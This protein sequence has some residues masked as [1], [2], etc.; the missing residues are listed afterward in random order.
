MFGKLT[1]NVEIAGPFKIEV[2]PYTM[3]IS[4]KTDISADKSTKSPD[5]NKSAE[6]ETAAAKPL[7]EEKPAEEASVNAEGESVSETEPVEATTAAAVGE[8]E[9][10]AEETGGDWTVVSVAIGVSAA[11]AGIVI[12]K[13]TKIV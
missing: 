5:T 6:S 12:L 4:Q 13:I 11:A 3:T 2:K 9:V 8:I 1:A 10:P 7:A